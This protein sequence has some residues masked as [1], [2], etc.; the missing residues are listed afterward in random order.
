MRI[1]RPLAIRK[2]L[3]TVRARGPMLRELNKHPEKSF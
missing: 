2:W 1:N 3:P